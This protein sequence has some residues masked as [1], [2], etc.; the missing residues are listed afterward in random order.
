[1]LGGY[2]KNLAIKDV[3][4]RIVLLKRNRIENPTDLDQPRV[5]YLLLHKL[6]W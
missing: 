5:G 2:V 3:T 4:E 6:V 1:M